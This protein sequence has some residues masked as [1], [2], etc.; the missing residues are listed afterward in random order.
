MAKNHCCAHCGASLGAQQQTCPQCGAPNPQY[1]PAASSSLSKKGGKP[2]TIA[3]LKAFCDSRGMPLEKMRFFIGIDYKQPRAFGIYK[4]D[5]TFIVYKNKAD[6]SRAIRYKGPDEAFAV[7]EL[8]DKLM[9]EHAL[10]AGKGKTARSGAVTR[11][12]SGGYSGIPFLSRLR[13]GLS[14]LFHSMIPYLIATL[15]VVMISCTIGGIRE[16]RHRND[17]YYRV[18]EELFYRYG[19]DWFANSLAEGWY[20]VDE[21]PYSD[22]TTYYAGESFS[23][24]W[25]GSSFKDSSIWD[26]IKDSSSDSDSDSGWDYSDWDSSDTDWDSDW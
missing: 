14:E 24:S 12:T 5:S 17:G 22:Y 26:D 8:Y 25:G 11:S 10:R 6:G 21:F 15:I 19:A 16:L 7:G 3:E 9:A 4:S 2:R 13:K 18:G 20:E 23:S 1:D